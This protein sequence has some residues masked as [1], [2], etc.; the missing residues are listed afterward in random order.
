MALTYDAAGRLRMTA[1]RLR[2]VAMVGL[3]DGV[4]AGW[5]AVSVH[6]SRTVAPAAQPLATL[7][8]ALM[9]TADPACAVTLD[10]MVTSSGALQLLATNTTAPRC[11]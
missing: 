9:A 10:G 2:A 3:I 6:A 5:M 4:H 8:S 7:T 1:L 11:K